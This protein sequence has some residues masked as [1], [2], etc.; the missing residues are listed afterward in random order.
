[1]SSAQRAARINPAEDGRAA[2]RQNRSPTKTGIHA[3][4]VMMRK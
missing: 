1:M 4:R 3:D 2:A